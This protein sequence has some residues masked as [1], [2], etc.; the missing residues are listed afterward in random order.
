MFVCVL[1]VYV[2]V[3]LYTLPPPTKLNWM[4][5]PISS[6]R[7]LTSFTGP[8]V[9]HQVNRFHQVTHVNPTATTV[10]E[11]RE[12]EREREKENESRPEPRT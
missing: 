2:C 1:C 11:R 8:G 5:E 3:C 10:G 9:D 12:G 4:T 6:L 7:S